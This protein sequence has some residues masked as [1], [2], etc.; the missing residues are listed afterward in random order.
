MVS[1]ILVLAAGM[2]LAACSSGGAEEK[3]DYAT[4]SSLCGTAVSPAALEPLLPAG[5]KISSVKSGPSGFTRCRLVVDKQVAVTSIIDQRKSGTRLMNVAY[6]TYGMRSDEI[7][8]NEHDYI[9]SDSQAVGHVSCSKLQKEG[10]E[11]FTM[12]R[13]EHGTVDATAMEKA[14][15]EFTDAVSASRLCTAPHA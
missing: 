8:K 15:T 14:I 6:G 10:H 9:V 12:I 13:K 11:L 5:N 4:P 7:K 3:R 2:A 1:V